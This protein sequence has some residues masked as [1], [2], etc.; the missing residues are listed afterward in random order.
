MS[1]DKLS[2]RRGPPPFIVQLLRAPLTL[3]N[4]IALAITIPV[5]R[6]RQVTYFNQQSC[7]WTNSKSIFGMLAILYALSIGH[8]ILTVLRFHRIRREVFGESI[9]AS[10]RRWR[11][12]GAI[13]L[14]DEDCAMRRM[15]FEEMAQ[16]MPSLLVAIPD[17][18]LALAFL[19]LYIITTLIATMEGKIELGVAYSSIGSL[20]AL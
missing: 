16:R 8:N 3:N 11:N 5:H 13:S 20:V 10:R 14:N 2:A 4:A 7:S 1:F 6:A 15:K 19:G 17:I 12:K 18:V 9:C